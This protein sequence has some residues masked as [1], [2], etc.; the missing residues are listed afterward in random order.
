[1]FPS[2]TVAPKPLQK[3]HPPLWVAARHP[4]T[5]NWALP[6]GCNIMS[7]ALTRPFSEVQ[8]YKQQFD[9]ALARSPE[10]KRPRFA[11][12]RATAVYPKAGDSPTYVK[13]IV[14]ATQYF[15]NLFK[16]LGEVTNGFPDPIPVEDL[17]NKDLLEPEAL[18]TNLVFGMPETVIAKLR[19]YEALGVDNFFYRAIGNLPFELQKQSLKLFIDEVMPAFENSRHVPAA[20]E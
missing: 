2:S 5:Y 10:V 17:D 9:E 11:T 18:V 6:L 3:P 4:T 7:W 8:K 13:A 16:Q 1:S 12:M 20:A 19:Q 15:E 14:E